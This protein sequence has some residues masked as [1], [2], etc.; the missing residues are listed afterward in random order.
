VK[1]EYVARPYTCESGML[2]EVQNSI[3]K[4]TRPQIILKVARQRKEF[5]Q[6]NIGYVEKDATESFSQELKSSVK[7]IMYMTQRKVLDIGLQAA[8]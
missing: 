1:K 5:G 4:N 2:E 6:D 7:N 8:C 3:I